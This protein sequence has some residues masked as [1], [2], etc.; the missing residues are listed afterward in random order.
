MRGL[1]IGPVGE[2]LFLQFFEL[3]DVLFM[4]QL[5]AHV[6]LV[7]DGLVSEQLAQSGLGLNQAQLSRGNILFELELLQR[8]F[9]VVAF[10]Q[11]ASRETRFV[12]IE[13]L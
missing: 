7:G 11:V 6:E 5:P 1:Q 12:Q 10:G 13:F 3:N 4:G 8:Q 9:E 2:R